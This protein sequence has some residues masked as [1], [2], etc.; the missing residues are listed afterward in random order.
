MRFKTN[1]RITLKLSYKKWIL[2]QKTNGI[3]WKPIGFLKPLGLGLWKPATG[4]RTALT[5]SRWFLPV[6]GQIAVNRWE[7]VFYFEIA[8]KLTIRRSKLR[9]LIYVGS[10]FMFT[11]PYKNLPSTTIK[12]ITCLCLLCVPI[13]FK[14]TDTHLKC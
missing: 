5:E 6:F 14:Y 3:L 9:R 2:V 12:H 11:E 4:F 13:F 8:D 10:A 7:T 1:A